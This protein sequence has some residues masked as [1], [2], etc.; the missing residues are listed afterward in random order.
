MDLEQPWDDYNPGS[1]IATTM[2]R[3]CYL[4]FSAQALKSAV[5]QPWP[6]QHLP[7]LV[8]I[9]LYF[10]TICEAAHLDQ[11]LAAQQSLL[12]QDPR[13]KIVCWYPNPKMNHNHSSMLPNTKTK[14]SRVHSVY[15]HSHSTH[16]MIYL[17]IT[18]GTATRRFTKF[19]LDPL[20]L[21]FLETTAPARVAARFTPA[22]CFGCN[23][24]L[25]NLGTVNLP[26]IGKNCL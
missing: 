5:D 20:S 23:G 8:S 25:R 24:W 16:T 14:F 4:P 22:C 11:L 9:R 2:I 15:T 13:R 12:L 7:Q 1:R 26:I 18:V 6:P 17:V 10:Y 19:S 21:V 3:A